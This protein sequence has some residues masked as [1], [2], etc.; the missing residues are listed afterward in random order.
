MGLKHGSTPLQI[1]P[2]THFGLGQKFYFGSYFA[3]D[4]G[5]DCLVYR[6]LTWS[7]ENCDGNLVRVSPAARPI[8]LL[9][10]MCF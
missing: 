10:K 6:G 1:I 5:F 4:I 8:N 9:K 3:L 2:A 7:L